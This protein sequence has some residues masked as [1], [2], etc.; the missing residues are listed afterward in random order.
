MRGLEP[1]PTFGI[2]ESRGLLLARDGRSIV[3]VHFYKSAT[4]Y[5]EHATKFKKIV[6]N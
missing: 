3:K 1:V 6:K 5:L 4:E 2:I